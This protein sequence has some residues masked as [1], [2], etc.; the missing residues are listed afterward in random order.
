[1]RYIKMITCTLVSIILIVGM[2]V[3]AYASSG[4]VRYTYSTTHSMWVAEEDN[5]LGTAVLLPFTVN[6]GA[7]FVYSKSDTQSRTF[8]QEEYWVKVDG[9]ITDYYK[10]ML[11]FHMFDMVVYPEQATSKTCSFDYLPSYIISSNYIFF[12]ITGSN[13]TLNIL[14]KGNSYGWLLYT[15]GASDDIN[16]ITQSIY[17]NNLGGAVGTVGATTTPTAVPGDNDMIAEASTPI[18][19]AELAQNID[20]IKAKI[21][22]DE[23]QTET[24]T[25]KEN[26][27][28]VALMKYA[29]ENNILVTDE[30]VDSYIE[31]CPAN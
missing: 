8:D 16:P 2:T 12:D 14:K 25:L 28:Y 5:G 13:T 15:I 27:K 3:T 10:N 6:A 17:F 30:E 26:K 11:T 24:I 20:L 7:T 9:N 4:S 23:L 31:C 21:E 29:E 1:M 22:E 18:D 19:T